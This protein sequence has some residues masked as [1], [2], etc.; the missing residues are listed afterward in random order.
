M[1]LLILG[2]NGMIGHTLLEKI[3]KFYEVKATLKNKLINYKELR[4]TKSEYYFENLNVLDFDKL[5]KQIQYFLPDVIINA[6]GITKQ[7]INNYNITEIEEI[8][9]LFPHKLAKLCDSL[10]IKL[11]HLSTDCVFSG[12]KGFYNLEDTPDA[13][14]IYG[15]SKHKGEVENSSVLTLRKSTIGFEV[16]YKKGLLEWFL[17]QKGNVNGYTNSIFSGIT[18]LELAKVLIYMLE[19]KINLKGTYHVSS[20]PIDKFRLLKIIKNKLK[21]D[22]ILIKPYKEFECDRSLDGT[23][24]LNKTNYEFPS[25]EIMIDEMISFQRN[26]RL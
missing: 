12:E 14:D 19:K 23:L 10:N 18:T 15:I 16:N 5:K 9:S 21:L 3:K 6:V 8:N 1:K 20:K 2:G 13:K 24:F 26:I 11:I 7:K 4:V 17:Q 25:W 22:S